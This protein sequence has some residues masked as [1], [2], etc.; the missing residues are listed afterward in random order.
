M[1]RFAWEPAARAD[2]RRIERNQALTI[3]HAL[4]RYGRT[5]VGDIRKLT[6]DQQ[7][8]YRFRVGDWRV[9]LKPEGNDVFRVYS[10][11]NRKDAYRA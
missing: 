9:I 7:G 11:D 10:V 2:L 6:A 3:L 1:S 5:G 4:G 8:R